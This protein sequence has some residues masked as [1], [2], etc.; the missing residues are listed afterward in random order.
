MKV[1]SNAPDNLL[2]IYAFMVCVVVRCN[3]LSSVSPIP[4]SGGSRGWKKWV[5]GVTRAIPLHV[6]VLLSQG[7]GLSHRSPQGLS[8]PLF[9]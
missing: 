2:C 6:A 9:W 8:R 7:T 4:P 1:V 3:E 5:S